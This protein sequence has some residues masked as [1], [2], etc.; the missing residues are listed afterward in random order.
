MNEIKAF[1]E[2]WLNLLTQWRYTLNLRH[3]GLLC[4]FI[5]ERFFSKI[6]LVYKL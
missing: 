4:A 3:L 2:L 6:E 1:E 5:G